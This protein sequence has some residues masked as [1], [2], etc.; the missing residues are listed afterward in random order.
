MFEMVIVTG[1][2]EIARQTHF[3]MSQRLVENVPALSAEANTTVILPWF[4]RKNHS[5]PP[6]VVHFVSTDFLDIYE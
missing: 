1:S 3:I 5:P 4:T 2:A 6:L